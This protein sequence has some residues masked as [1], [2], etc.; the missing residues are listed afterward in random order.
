M[1]QNT[2]DTK[3]AQYEA[4]LAT[5][6]T[7]RDAVIGQRAIHAG[8]IKYLPQLAG[9]SKDAYDAYKRRSL[10]FGATG[11]TKEAMTGLVFRRYPKIS[12]TDGM[13]EFENDI[14]M[15]G[16]SLLGFAQNCIEEV[17]EVGRAGVLIDYP[18]YIQ[19]DAPLTVSQSRAAG[20]RPYMTL[21]KTESIINWQFG[22]VANATV[23]INVFLAEA[24]ES[25]AEKLQIRELHLEDGR[26]GQRIWRQINKGWEV[27]EE[28][29][30]LRSGTPINEIPFWFLAPKEGLGDVQN[31]PIESLV[32]VNL[33]HYMNSADLENGAHVAG[34]PTPWVN[35]V[36]DPKNFP[37]LH[38]GSDT[39]L[40]LPPDST[41]GFL[42]CGSEGFATLEKLMDRKEQQM[43]A[44]GARMLA[45]EKR[46]AEAAQ[47]HELKRGGENSVLSTLAASVETTLT[48]ALQFMAEWLGMNP[49]N[50]F[51]ELNKDYLPS[52]MD[53]SML[54]EWVAAY[55]A[56]TISFET[57]IKTLQ[58]GE[59]ISENITAEEEREKIN[60]EG[61]K[62]GNIG[63]V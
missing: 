46:Q 4:M 19:S 53:S 30:P 40:S 51:I 23:L 54:R 50:V 62:L 33:S 31:P 15:A 7:C 48:K 27:A 60:A 24:D 6:R 49:A 29:W 35:G 11:R 28:I 10:F 57:F 18:S 39:F 56:G 41:A 55:Q 21:Y 44:L 59:L 3:H 26:Y 52:P 36:D 12:L 25:D 17:L 42:Q 8:G 63:E 14:D 13:K 47:T 38:L 43:A 2:P 58:D 61:P 45:P 22:R 1:T 9:Q 32:Y 37:E 5:W 34:Q 16:V 20:M